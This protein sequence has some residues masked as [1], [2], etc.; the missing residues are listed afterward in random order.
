MRTADHEYSTLVVLEEG[1]S[2]R[3]APSC[4]HS[5]DIKFSQIFWRPFLIVTGQL[6]MRK[7][8]LYVPLYL[9]LFSTFLYTY[10]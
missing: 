7:F 9:A 2:A 4:P 3:S 1:S 8:R 5:A 6:T 10:I